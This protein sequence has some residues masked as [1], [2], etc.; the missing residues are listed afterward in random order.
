M[1]VN[2]F[3]KVWNEHP[4]VR[5]RVGCPTE[6]ESAIQ[7][8]AQERFQS[9]YMFWRGDTKMIYVFLWGSPNDTVG[10]WQQFPDTWNDG[11]PEPTPTQPAPSGLYTPVRGFGKVWRENNLRLSLGY[12]IE[13]EQ[14]ATGAWQAYDHGYALW[15]A[16]KVIRFM[17]ND[18]ANGN[19]WMRFEDT[20]VMPT[21]TPGH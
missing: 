13:T 10:S 18:N 7:I 5:S 17:F 3:G 20:Y 2:G 21:A 11:D 9:G 19:I 15:T 6:Y 1:P 14:A 12:A 16:D 4:E 8:A